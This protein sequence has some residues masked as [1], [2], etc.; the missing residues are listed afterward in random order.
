MALT[1]SYYYN[2]VK[3][4]NSTHKFVNKLLIFCIFFSVVL[5]VLLYFTSTVPLH[6]Q[7]Q[8]FIPI[9]KKMYSYSRLIL[10]ITFAYTMILSIVIYFWIRY[11][12]S[13]NCSYRGKLYLCSL[14]VALCFLLT[15]F[16]VKSIEKS[17]YKAFDNLGRRSENLVLAIERYHDD[18]GAYPHGLKELVPFYIPRIPYTGIPLY[19]AYEY[20]PAKKYGRFKYYE[21]RVKSPGNHSKY[22]MFFYW[23]EGRYQKYTYGGIV[24][25]IGDWAYLH[26]EPNG[27]GKD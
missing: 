11:F 26:E 8:S 5:P 4:G 3:T 7:D 6:Q 22:D 21:L 25:R 9:A 12:L 15:F 18:F 20:E 17:R 19:P 1:T 16:V 2:K 27:L 14:I 10:N 24:E 13:P 23:P